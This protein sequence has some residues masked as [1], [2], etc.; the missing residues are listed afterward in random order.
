[1]RWWVGA[2]TGNGTFPS[3]A[4]Y[5]PATTGRKSYGKEIFQGRVQE[6]RGRDEEAQERH[7]QERAL[8]KEGQEPQAGDCDRP[9]RSA[10]SGEEGAEKEDRQKGR[11]Q[12]FKTQIV[13]EITEGDDSGRPL[14]AGERSTRIVRCAAGEGPFHALRTRGRPS[15]GCI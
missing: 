11:P 6:S 14:P 5:F 4:D 7:A 8:R 10:Q 15:P 1:M 3:R 2:I 13:E 12:E 9:F